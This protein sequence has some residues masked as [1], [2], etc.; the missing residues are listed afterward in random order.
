VK[1]LWDTPE[2]AAPLGIPFLSDWAKDDLT[3]VSIEKD[4]A[5][6]DL[7][8]QEL[9]ILKSY[10][11]DNMSDADKLNTDILSWYMKSQIEERPY[12]LY[13]YPVNPYRGIQNGFLNLMT[14][15]HELKNKSDIK[16]YIERLKKFKIKAEQTITVLKV[17]EDS[18]FILPRQQIDKVLVEMNSF[19]GD[20]TAKDIKSN[21]LY[22]NFVERI[23]KIESVSDQK[24][25]LYSDEVERIIEE[26]IIPSYETLIGYFVNVRPK[27][28]NDV[29]AWVFPKGDA[30][31]KHRLRKMTTT[32][33]SPEYIHSLGLSEVDR[34]TSEMIAIIESFGIIDSTLTLKL[35]LDSLLK[36][37]PLTKIDVSGDNGAQK[38]LDRYKEIIDSIY[39]KVDQY[40]NRLPSSSI[41]VRAVPLAREESGGAYYSRPPR[42]GSRPGVFYANTKSAKIHDSLPA[43]GMKTL[44]YHEGVPGHHFHSALQIEMENVPMFRN[45]GLFPAFNEGWALYAEQ[46]AY[47]MGMYNDDPLGNLG[48]LQQELF[49]AVRLVVDTGIHYKKWSRQ[50][51]INY[52]KNNAIMGDNS[53]TAEI[54]RYINNPGQACAY[55][56][57]MIKILELRQLAKSELGEDFD[58]KRFHDV[59]LETGSVPLDILEQVVDDFIT[60]TTESKHSINP[61]M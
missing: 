44:A 18:S 8:E 53:A 45:I 9:A 5:Y 21:M 60:A 3:E 41:E 28:S 25:D 61:E 16:A 56:L 7:F 36:I 27:S 35:A 48:R 1:A 43:I 30:Y 12:A 6:F 47:E 15:E 34:I 52:M 13:D 57:G 32:N 22:T 31:Y 50:K 58:I 26:E 17:R 39:L 29:G 54:D 38:Y 2:R 14:E 19:I 49:R 55:K 33:Y 51:A 10:D 42:N 46:L 40:F 37:V 59:I 4:M 24:K 20:S 11:Y 23:D